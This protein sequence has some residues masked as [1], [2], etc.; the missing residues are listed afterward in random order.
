MIGKL[1]QFFSRI[2]SLIYHAL[3]KAWNNYQ[4]ER[5]IKDAE[6]Q[7]LNKLRRE[8]YY[9]ELGK[10]QALRDEERDW[11]IREKKRRSRE[12]YLKEYSRDPVGLK[13]LDRMLGLPKRKKQ[14]RK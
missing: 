4:R 6:R 13:R 7:R 10:R 8:G 11:Q 3:R 12:E 1:F 5:A 2:I 14:K 9:T